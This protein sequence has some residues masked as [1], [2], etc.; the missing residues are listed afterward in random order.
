MLSSDWSES[1]GV[2]CTVMLAGAPCTVAVIP[3]SAPKLKSV[4]V[5]MPDMGFAVLRVSR[6]WSGVTTMSC[7]VVISMGTAKVLS[8]VVVS[9]R[10][11]VELARMIR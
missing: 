10:T 4:R 1:G 7:K 9:G 6:V 8:L 11:F 5:S 3:V 2:T